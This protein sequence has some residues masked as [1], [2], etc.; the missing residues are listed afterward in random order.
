[1]ESILKLNLQPESEKASAITLPRQD[2][3]EP[4]PQAPSRRFNKFVSR[5]AHKAAAHSSRGGSGMFT[6]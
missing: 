5:T 4:K 2:S 1:M 3:E 6:K